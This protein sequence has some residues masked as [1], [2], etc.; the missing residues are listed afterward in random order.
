[1]GWVIFLMVNAID[2]NQLNLGSFKNL[3]F[4]NEISFKK[5]VYLYYFGN[6]CTQ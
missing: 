2:I 1:M 3:I 6:K 5:H 4:K